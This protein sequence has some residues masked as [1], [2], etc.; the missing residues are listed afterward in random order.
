MSIERLKV[1]KRLFLSALNFLFQVT[2]LASTAK[3]SM[4][5]QNVICAAVTGKFFQRFCWHGQLELY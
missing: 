3:K 2:V 1:I 4:W 5:L